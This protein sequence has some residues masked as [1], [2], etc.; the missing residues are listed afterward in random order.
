MAASGSTP[1]RSGRIVFATLILAVAVGAV[2][3]ATSFPSDTAARLPLLVGVPMILL[4][5]VNLLRELR[6]SA[7]GTEPTGDVVAQTLSQIDGTAVEVGSFNDPSPGADEG[8]PLPWAL[9]AVCLFVV[10]YLVFGQLVSIPLGIA[11]LLRMSRQSWIAV[12]LT[13]AVTWAVIFGIS[14]E[15]KVQTHPGWVDLGELIG[16]P[17]DA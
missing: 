12:V 7:P 17:D 2:A 13:S 10:L 3:M 11:I 6:P 9:F 14:T 1:E 5:L 8:L 16:G 15:L 4:A